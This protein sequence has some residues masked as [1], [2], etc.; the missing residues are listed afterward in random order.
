MVLLTYSYYWQYLP[1]FYPVKLLKIHTGI[2]LPYN[3]IVEN[4]NHFLTDEYK[5]YLSNNDLEKNDFG[6]FEQ[7]SN[8]TK[9][10]QEVCKRHGLTN[11]N[12]LIVYSRATDCC[13]IVAILNQKNK[14]LVFSFNSD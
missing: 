13:D 12:S 4:H 9:H 10:L 5:Y 3:T 14:V 6:Q 8:K 1:P 2:N 11:Y 7:F